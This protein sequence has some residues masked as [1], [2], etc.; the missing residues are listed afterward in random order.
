MGQSSGA[1]H[2][3]R[4]GVVEG[5]RVVVLGVSRIDELAAESEKLGRSWVEIVA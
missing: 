5:A 1:T 2:T 3:R 4:C